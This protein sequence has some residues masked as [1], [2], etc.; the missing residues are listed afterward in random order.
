[1]EKAD[2]YKVLSAIRRCFSRSK[3]HREVLNMAKTDELGPKGGKRYRCCICGESFGIKEVHVDHI[4]C[5]V[6]LDKTAESMTWD[7]IIKRIFCDITNLQV[8]CTTDHKI[9]SKEENLLRKGGLNRKTK[10]K[11]NSSGPDCGASK[12]PKRRRKTDE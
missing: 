8:I 10:G 1:M 4:D 3:T 2:F 5:V 12:K 6:P 11:Q 9:K 7:E